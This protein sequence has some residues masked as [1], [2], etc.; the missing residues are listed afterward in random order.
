MGLVRQWPLTMDE[1]FNMSVASLTVF[2][3]S[4]PQTLLTRLS[5]TFPMD[6]MQPTTEY[7]KIS[8]LNFQ[9]LDIKSKNA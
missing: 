4:P 7:S 9:T 1:G 3:N 5:K 8:I 2:R 6:L